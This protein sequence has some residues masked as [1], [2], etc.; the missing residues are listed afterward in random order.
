MLEG[1]L[2]AAKRGKA[3]LL[4]LLGFPQQKCMEFKTSIKNTN[5]IR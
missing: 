5:L 1:N 4:E 2:I 3:K